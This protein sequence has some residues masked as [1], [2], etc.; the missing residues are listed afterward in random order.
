VG[1]IGDGEKPMAIT[2]VTCQARFP[3]LSKARNTFG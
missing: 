3:L 1:A 2:M